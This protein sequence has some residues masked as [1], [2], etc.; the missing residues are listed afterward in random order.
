VL[1]TLVA[2]Q[3][4]RLDQEHAVATTIEPSPV[5]VQSD[6]L[7]SVTQDD[8]TGVVVWLVG[9][10]DLS[11]VGELSAELARA[12]TLGD[13]DVVVDLTEVRHL[14]AVT[15]G[16]LYRTRELLRTRSRRLVMR[17][18]PRWVCRMLELSGDADLL[19][20]S[21]PTPATGSAD[22]LRTWVPVP[23]PARA[24]SAGACRQD[25]RP[26]TVVTGPG[27]T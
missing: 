5:A 17:S 16:V 19:T 8:A 2:H 9:E 25:E 11:T 7:P 24:P 1:R 6:G 26:T 10:H 22:A 27:A 3:F 13:G 18:P 21:D 12:I 15:I 20:P 4:Q 23:V 14:Q